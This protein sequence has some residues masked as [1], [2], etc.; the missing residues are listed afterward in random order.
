MRADSSYILADRYK[1]LFD[2]KS[3]LEVSFSFTG[4]RMFQSI[5]VSRVLFEI[6]IYGEK[7][8]YSYKNPYSRLS[9]SIIQ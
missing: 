6:F 7:Q 2:I 9:L 1:M 3:G 5:S 8:T 4:D